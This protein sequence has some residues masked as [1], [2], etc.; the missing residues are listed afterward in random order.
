MIGNSLLLLMANQKQYFRRMKVLFGANLLRHYPLWEASGTALQDISPNAANG[1]QVNAT[2]AQTGIGDGR[3]SIKF[4]ATSYGNFYSA[5]F[6][7]AFNPALFSVSI[8]YKSNLAD[9]TD[10]VIDYLFQIAAD[11][12]NAI[13]AYNSNIAN[14]MR[15]YY[16]G[17]GVSK[18][19]YVGALSTTEWLNIIY[20]INKATDTWKIRVQGRS[21]GI[22]VTGLGVWSGALDATKCAIGSRY[23]N[24]SSLPC[25]GWLAHVM[26]VNNHE[27]T[28]AE[29]LEV[30]T[31]IA[32]HTNVLIIGDSKSNGYTD[33]N[34]K[35]LLKLQ[36]IGVYWRQ[37]PPYLAV[38]GRKTSDFYAST[39]ADIAGMTFTPQE[40]IINLGANDVTGNVLAANWDRDTRYIVN[41]YHTAFPAARISLTKIWRRGCMTAVGQANALIDQMLIDY[42]PWLVLGCN[43]ALFLENGDDGATYTT[44]GTHPND[45]GNELEASARFTALGY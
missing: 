20:S 38:G 10:G 19:M 32:N 40:I 29:A 18:T 17:G 16:Y 7:S 36:A 41:A 9:W 1:N 22:A 12:N 24:S 34:L 13:Q 11:D 21:T 44:D 33:W 30:A 14:V 27:I 2:L 31:P 25:K 42:A 23:G 39:A 35:L 45:A 15:F 37:M 5:A 8:W 6:N 4:P 28:D 3:T 26:I 43:E